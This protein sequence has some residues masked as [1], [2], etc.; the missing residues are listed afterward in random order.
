MGFLPLH[1]LYV[2]IYLFIVLF[3]AHNLNSANKLKLFK[4]IMYKYIFNTFLNL[5]LKI[6]QLVWEGEI[7]IQDSRFK[8]VY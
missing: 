3:I 8:K 2:F 7:K 6:H 1:A 5:S 4:K